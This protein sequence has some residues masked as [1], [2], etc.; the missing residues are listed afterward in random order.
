MLD[1][2]LETTVLF[3]ILAGV[4]GL[5]R[6]GVFFDFKN[7]SMEKDLT[8]RLAMIDTEITVLTAQVNTNRCRISMSNHASVFDI[9]FQRRNN[10]GNSIKTL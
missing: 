2:C 4:G 6:R 9:E 8:I 7:V 10:V 3:L 1:I 5:L